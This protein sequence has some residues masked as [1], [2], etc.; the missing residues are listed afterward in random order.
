MA[1]ATKETTTE[2]KEQSALEAAI[3]AT[4]A[5]DELV[6]SDDARGFRSMDNVDLGTN[7]R[8]AVARDKLL[9]LLTDD[10]LRCLSGLMNTDLGFQTDRPNERNPQ[11]Y[12]ISEIRIPIADALLRGFRMHNNEFNIIA[13]KFYAAR[14]GCERLVREWPG[15]TECYVTPGIPHING[16]NST[17]PMTINYTLNGEEREIKWEGKQSICVR[18]NKAMGVDAVIGKAIRKAY[19]RTLER[20]G[21]MHVIDEPEDNTPSTTSAED[22]VAALKESKRKG[23]NESTPEEDTSIWANKLKQD[24]GNALTDI[25][26]ESIRR[27]NKSKAFSLGCGEWLDSMCNQ[28]VDALMQMDANEA[29]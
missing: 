27:K 4:T 3:E 8:M 29:E 24:I 16:Q 28:R 18:V 26:I 21:G 7:I 22:R 19:A 10:V 2:V 13:T 5:I 25:E 20:L 14:T 11:P 23:N 9:K 17:V 1:K 15:M 12:S 6:G